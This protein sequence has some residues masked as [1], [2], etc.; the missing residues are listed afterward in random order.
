MDT[1]LGDIFSS[2]ADINL[3]IRREL[4]NQINAFTWRPIDNGDYEL[5]LFKGDQALSVHL[6][7]SMLQ[8]YGHKKW[9]KRIRMKIVETFE[10]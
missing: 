1:A 7:K 3:F 8:K 6:S 2:R 10:S 9:N 5:K 4:T